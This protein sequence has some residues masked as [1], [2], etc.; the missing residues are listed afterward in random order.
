[1]AKTRKMSPSMDAWRKHVAKV[2][3]AEGVKY[4]DAMRMA[5]KGKYA[6]EWKQIQASVSKGKKGGSHPNPMPSAGGSRRR[7]RGGMAMNPAELQ[8][9]GEGEEEEMPM[10][11]GEPAAYEGKF[12]SNAASFKGGRRRTRKSRSRK[13]RKG[14]RGGSLLVAL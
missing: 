13:G 8:G 4:G 2:A 7:K 11:G 10:Q 9:G 5:N 14:K 6:S 1:M 12:G 3:S